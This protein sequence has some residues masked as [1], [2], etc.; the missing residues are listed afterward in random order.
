MDGHSSQMALSVMFL[1]ATYAPLQATA[2]IR[3]Q[4]TYRLFAGLPLLGMVP[5]IIGA[6]SPGAYQDGSLF[7]MYFCFP[8]LPSMIYC[9]VLAFSQPTF[10]PSCRRQIIRKSFQPL[11]TVCP[12]CSAALSPSA[13][14]PPP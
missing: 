3:Q 4:G 6:M 2:I 11:P 1:L 5:M 7:G 8:Y 14:P 9:G 13:D 10:C 12:H